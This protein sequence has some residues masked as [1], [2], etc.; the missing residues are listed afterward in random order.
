MTYY[1]SFDFSAKAF[2]EI[3]K[4]DKLLMQEACLKAQRFF[5]RD[6]FFVMRGPKETILE[7]VQFLN[8]QELN[9]FFKSSS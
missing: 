4:E 2:H 5:P 3:R 8:G 7:H 9:N 6:L 1:L